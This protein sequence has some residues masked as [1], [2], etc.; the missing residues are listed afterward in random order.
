MTVEGIVVDGDLRV[1]REDLATGRERERVHLDERGIDGE[2]G[3]VECGDKGDEALVRLAGEPE[4]EG[5]AACLEALE[6]K[7]RLHILPHDLL[8]RLLG[9][10][11]DL[12][13]TLG[14]CHDDVLA[15]GAIEEDRA[16]EFLVDIDAIGDQQTVHHLPF[17]AGLYCHQL[18]AD[19]AG[20]DLV[21][22]VERITL[23]DREHFHAAE[24]LAVVHDRLVGAHVVDD[25][26]AASA[27][28]DL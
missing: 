20:G 5:E 9:D 16:I 25:S 19:N 1:D 4:P 17:A 10:L 2:I 28:M 21:H 23:I 26:L 7:A 12:H 3:I 15:G 24:F 14:R 18:V 13:A 22:F 11:L 6:A 8:R 27:G